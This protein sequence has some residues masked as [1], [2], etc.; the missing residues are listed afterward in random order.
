[1]EEVKNMTDSMW[2]DLSRDSYA[3]E[4]S[5]DPLRRKQTGSYYTALDLTLAMMREMIEGMSEE[6]RKQIDSKKFLEPCVGTGNFV[7]AYLRVCQE[8]GLTKNQWS[9]LLENIYVCDINTDALEVYKKNLTGFAWECCGIAL[10]EAYFSKHIGA[11]LM[12]NVDDD[13][14]A[15]IPIEQVFSKDIIGDGFDFVVTNPPYKNL[16]AEKSHYKNDQTY[17]EDKR[18]YAEIAKLACERFPYS[19]AGTWNLYKMFVEEIVEKYASKT[20][21]C[22][23]LIPASILSDKTCAKLRTRILETT[24]IQSLRVIAEKSDYVDASQALCAVLLHKG[25]KTEQISID[26]SFCGDIRNGTMVA[27]DDFLD[28]ST[29][30]AILVLTEEEYRIRRKMQECPRIKEIPYI[31][32]LRGELDL[33]LNKNAIQTTDTPYPLLRGRH[34]G[35]YKLTDVPVDEFVNEGFVEGT[36][37]KPYIHRPRL[38]C[39]QIVNMAKKHRIA[40]APIPADYVLGNSCNFISVLDN[41]DGV[42]DLFLLGILNS[43]LIDWFFKLTSSNNHINNYEIDNFPIPVHFDKKGRVADLVAEYM[44]TGKAELL[45]EIESLA[46][47]AYGLSPEAPGETRTNGNERES[48]LDNRGKAFSAFVEAVH[49]FIQDASEE[50]CNAVITGGESLA[51]LFAKHNV[52]PTAFDRKVIAGIETKFRSL[53]EG[54]I[55]NHTTFKLSDLDLEMIRSVPQGGNWK[56]IP[57]ETVQKSKRLA[58]ITQTGGRTTLYGRIDYSKPSYTITTYFNRPG[59]GTYVHPVHER[60]L[61]VREAARFQCFPDDYLFCGNKNDMLK[62]VGNAVPVLL[63]YHIGRAIKEKTGCCTSVDLFSGAGGM[64]YG[65]KRA[66]I[67]AVIANDIVENACVTLKTNAPEIPV[68]CGDITLQETKDRIIKAGIEGGADILCG[69]PPCQGF[70]MAGW[71]MKDDPRNQLFRHFVDIVSGVNPKVIVFENVE[72]L[73]SFR[74]GETYRNIIELF[75]E[76]GYYTEGRTL[77]AN[78]YGAPQRR[79]RVIIL[80]TRKDIGVRPEDIF[81]APITPNADQQITAYQ[82]IYD[83]ESV[84]CSEKARHNS[85]Y[86]SDILELLKG[87]NDMDE[88]VR[89]VTDA[90][91]VPD[92]IDDWSGDEDEEDTAQTTQEASAERQKTVTNNSAEG[93]GVVSSDEQ[94]SIFGFFNRE[95]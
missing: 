50:E 87:R 28:A 37:K 60:V 63:A 34:V 74:G 33:T 91:G 10:S 26:G 42:N 32:N 12:I 7:F 39:Q 11:G 88:Y 24:S 79:K 19:A 40:F 18:R 35:F 48:M 73:L 25:E 22:S 47:E 78:H 23:L 89:R 80:C 64:T 29:G 81:P 77:M 53:Y 2:D 5:M 71:R 54:I 56:N 51:A 3:F 62:Q 4:H 67:H 68:L 31:V 86:T 1:M 44:Q 82:T 49:C 76:L 43:N 17:M 45:Q 59:N 46:A 8:L 41:E 84:P 20:G 94:L 52:T 16:K 83:L 57:Q 15:Y 13:I 66:G 61:S 92:G 36:T 9:Q 72:G 58:R 70:S 6:D 55:L 69:G 90:R 95:Q 27:A 65:F 21:I 38:I 30:N 14:P 93:A 75:S 85:Q